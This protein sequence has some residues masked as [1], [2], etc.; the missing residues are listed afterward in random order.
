MDELT[1][2]DR[3]IR[4]QHARVLDLEINGKAET[5]LIRELQWDYLGKQMIHAIPNASLADAQAWNKSETE[6]WRKITEQVKIEL[7]Q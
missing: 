6:R 4:V 1:T 7:S 3:A 2:L 5:V